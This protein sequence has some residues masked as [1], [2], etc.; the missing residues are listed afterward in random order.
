MWFLVHR[1]PIPATVYLRLNTTLLAFLLRR[2]SFDPMFTE[3]EWLLLRRV[4]RR[5]LEELVVA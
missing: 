5:G 4:E 3:L 1:G 2:G